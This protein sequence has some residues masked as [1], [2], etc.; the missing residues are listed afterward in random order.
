[1]KRLQSVDEIIRKYAV[2]SSPWKSRLCIA[3]G[4]LFVIFAI[5][6]IWI[7]GW[8]TI[9]W[10]IPATFLFSISNERLFR[11]SLTNRYFGRPLFDYYATGKTIP[12][13][14]KVLV[15]AC[16]IVMTIASAYF[17]YEI[18][19]PADPGYGAATIVLC[20]IV[21]VGYIFGQVKTRIEPK[22]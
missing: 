20:G 7:P 18:S 2:T 13:H 15:S 16:I 8:P 22:K 5:I 21:G 12:A 9:S 1:M 17:V 3:L 6:G 11:W 14:A 10:A 4:Y 19:Y